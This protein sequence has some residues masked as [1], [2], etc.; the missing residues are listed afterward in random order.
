LILLDFLASKFEAT[1]IQPAAFLACHIRLKYATQ[2]QAY[3]VNG[4]QSNQEEQPRIR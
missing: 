3:L 4:A 2:A 1:N